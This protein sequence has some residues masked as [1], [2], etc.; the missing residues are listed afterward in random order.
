M[1]AKKRALLL[2]AFILSSPLF[3][4]AVLILMRNSHV[5][6]NG[7]YD[8]MAVAIAIFLSFFAYL[9]LRRKLG[10]NPAQ[11]LLPRHGW[12]V[13]GWAVVGL[14]LSL[15]PYLLIVGWQQI[16]W[17]N[18]RLE[19]I[20]AATV[21]AITPAFIEEVLFR[22]MLF[23]WMLGRYSVV[24]SIIVQVITFSAL[25]F[26]SQRFGWHAV[27]THVVGAILF[28]LL[29]LLTED[30]IAPMAAHFV[31]NFTL[32]IFDGIYRSY[33]V[34]A[35]LLYGET[36]VSLIYGHLALEALAILVVWWAWRR[37]RAAT[38]TQLP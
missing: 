1:I 20:F 32:A 11:P 7:T 23:R 38:L 6:R 3:L 13:A 31:W 25:H 10:E 8:T 35:G 24:G 2:L 16:H 29:W 18:L 14:L 4:I 34:R 30:F 22:D 9:W 28:S 19:L 5:P 26:F 37:Q 15:L 36:P 27:L 12:A 21:V 17:E 33:V